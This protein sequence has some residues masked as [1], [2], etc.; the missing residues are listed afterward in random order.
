LLGK[1][2][3]LLDPI[4]EIMNSGHGFGISNLLFVQIAVVLINMRS[5]GAM[6]KFKAAGIC[7][8]FW[9]LGNHSRDERNILQQCIVLAILERE[10]CLMEFWLSNGL[11][12]ILE[13]FSLLSYA[14]TRTKSSAR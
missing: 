7:Q 4:V 1:E 2:N 12:K 14:K 11:I 9:S 5:F 13:E 10:L 3:Q 6:R 8:G